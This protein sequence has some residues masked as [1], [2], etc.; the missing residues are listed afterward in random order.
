MP[1]RPLISAVAS[2]A[3]SPAIDLPSTAV[4]M[5]PSSI[6]ASLGGRVVEDGRDAQARAATSLTLRPTPEKRP[7]VDLLEARVGLGVE[8][9]GEAVLVAPPELVDHPRDRGVLELV[10][11][12][13]V[14]SS[15]P[16]SRRAP[17][18]SARLVVAEDSR[19]SLAARGSDDR[20]PRIA[21]G[22]TRACSAA[23]RT[24]AME[25]R[26][27]VRAAQTRRKR[28]SV[29]PLPSAETAIAAPSRRPRSAW[30]RRSSA[31]AATGR[32]C[33]QADRRWSPCP[34]RAA[35]PRSRRRSSRQTSPSTMNGQ[36]MNQL[37]APTSRITS[38]SRR[39]A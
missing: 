12:D 14:G 10:G 19:S 7:S 29:R 27:R 34:G 15:S 8:V 33:R 5:S 28:R 16:R 39:R 4:T 26:L 35:R 20:A 32:R 23:A 36:R 38:T 3:S 18:W 1:R 6:P 22:T 37:V 17:P 24:L 21:T 31:A 25:R 9:V 13:L 2:S 11:V 30:R